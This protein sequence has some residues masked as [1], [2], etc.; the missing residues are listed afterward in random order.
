MSQDRSGTSLHRKDHIHTR[1]RRVDPASVRLQ[2]RSVSKEVSARDIIDVTVVD[3]L[4]WLAD[5]RA[6]TTCCCSIKG[7][8][9]GEVEMSG[10]L[11]SLNPVSVPCNSIF[12]GPDEESEVYVDLRTHYT[13]LAK[14]AV[15]I[16]RSA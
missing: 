7:H 10:G 6:S 1:D 9:Q 16:N 5:G 8:S 14:A 13:Y 12:A 3:A 4:G 2:P 11:H 15:K